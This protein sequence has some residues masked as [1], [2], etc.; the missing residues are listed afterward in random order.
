GVGDGGF[1]PGG[2]AG[3]QERGERIAA[4][5]TGQVEAD[6]RQVGVERGGGGPVE[7]PGQIPAHE[8]CQRVGD[9]AAVG[10]E[11][12]DAG[13]SHRL[14]RG[15]HRLDDVRQRGCG[16]FAYGGV[17]GGEHGGG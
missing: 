12:L 14:G 10:D 17:E 3:H 9:G 15:E 8:S 7:Q 5:D 4:L 16:V 2:G 13:A 6:H 11:L 1:H